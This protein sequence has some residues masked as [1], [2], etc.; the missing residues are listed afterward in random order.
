M[1]AILNIARMHITLILQ[2]RATYVQ[3]FAVPIVL[4]LVL[5]T[6]ISG[7]NVVDVDVLIDVVDQ[8]ESA[9]SAD[10]IALLRTTGSL[11]VCQYGAE[12]IPSECDLSSNTDFDEVGE[13]RLQDGDVAAALVIPAGFGDALQNG[14][15][16]SP[17]LSQ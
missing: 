9:L 14:Q 6:A 8:D 2:D 7:D 4:M 16:A 1:N 10:F 3:G 12:S 17:R 13:E 5:A 15:A 11:T